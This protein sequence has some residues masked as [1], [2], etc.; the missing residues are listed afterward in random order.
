MVNQFQYDAPDTNRAYSVECA[1]ICVFK[2]AIKL[3]TEILKKS[4]ILCF[5]LTTYIMILKV[6]WKILPQA[7]TPPY[8]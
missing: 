6:G 3:F 7:I 4:A 5:G 1:D 8:S 2:G